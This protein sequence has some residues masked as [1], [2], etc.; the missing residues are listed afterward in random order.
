MVVHLLLGLLTIL[1]GAELFTNAVEWLGKRL[2]LSE[3][4]VGNLLAAVGTALPESIVPMV[5]FLS[6]GTDAVHIGVGAILGAPFMLGTLAMF[7][8]GF[9]A[10]AFPW[11]GEGRQFLQVN[12]RAVRR[13]M[14][15][16]LLMFVTALAAAFL[17]S[18]KMQY[19]IAAFLV[20]GYGFYAY[21]TVKHGQSLSEE[22][23]KPLYLGMRSAPGLGLILLQLCAGLSAIVGGANFFVAG[24]G[25]MA[26]LLG[27]Q[28][29]ILA[30]LIA[31]IATELPEKFNS[32][33]WI[34]QRKD[35]LALG[36]ITGAMVF[37][38]T[39]IP[40]FGMLAVQWRLDY[41]SLLSSGFTLLS[42]A[43]LYAGICARGRVGTTQLMLCGL[44]Y[45]GFLAMIVWC[46]L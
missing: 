23:L 17:P 26:V 13:D 33:I 12:E 20:L 32:V 6:G 43:S 25:Q 45:V 16:F 28:P 24:I 3:G 29:L 36:N 11:R 31:P 42:V 15:F 34:S 35:G 18:R 14:Q 46:V 8:T 19:G 37:Q 1:I 27:I 10:W 30:L 5:A 41:P 39:M 4:V 21:Q 2:R 40:A 44:C 9:A 7:I 38:S 22:N